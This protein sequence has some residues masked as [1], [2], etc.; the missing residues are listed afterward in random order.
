[1][2]V[3]GVTLVM[4]VLVVGMWS[5]IRIFGETEIVPSPTAV[6]TT[7]AIATST[8]TISPSTPLVVATPVDPDAP[9]WPVGSLPH[10]LQMAPDLLAEGSLPLNDIAR[11]SDIGGWMAAQA[12]GVPDS[13]PAAATGEWA[14]ALTDL[15]L[16]TSLREFGLDPLWQRTYGFDLTQV[17][18]VLVVGQAPDVVLL[19]RGSF[20][21]N[22]LM[23][24]WVASG[25]QPVERE[26][27]TVWTLSPGDGIDLSA[28]ESRL[29]LGALNNM[30]LLEDGTLVASARISRLGTVIQVSHGDADSLAENEEIAPLLVPDSGL[31]T[32]ASATLAQGTLL[33]ALP[34][35]TPALGTPVELP[36]MASPVAEPAAVLV[37]EMGEVA[38]VL[39]GIGLPVR[40]TVPF[41]LRLVMDEADT[42]EASAAMIEQ[43][44]ATGI[45][46]VDGRPYASILGRAIVTFEDEVVI[47]TA[48]HPPATLASLDLISERDLGFAFWYPAP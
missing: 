34:G 9:V 33:Q 13:L 32:L 28:P 24:A 17:H 15:A 2:R 22:A 31:E 46:S 30:I 42:T 48:S 35:A 16:P 14:D 21:S 18:Q 11:Y 5:L 12:V 37:P 7:G 10:L 27:E 39:I 4:A 43:R 44:L 40:G 6:P 1:M 26:G 20:D 3:G 38:V 45:S 36:A 47:V 8:P 25:Y 41:T 19:M 23:A 29:S